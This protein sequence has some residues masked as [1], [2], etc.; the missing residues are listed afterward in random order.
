VYSYVHTN[1]KK[2]N[3]RTNKYINKANIHTC[4]H[5]FVP[6]HAYPHT[7][8]TIHRYIQAFKHFYV[9]TYVLYIWCFILVCFF[10]SCV[11]C[12]CMYVYMYLHTHTM[13]AIYTKQTT[14][15]HAYSTYHPVPVPAYKS[16]CVTVSKPVLNTHKFVNKKMLKVNST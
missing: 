8:Y 13:C 6:L 14:Y 2:T 7:I 3:K 10:V 9:C 15:K 11:Q 12:A 5:A 4:F 1:K 16:V